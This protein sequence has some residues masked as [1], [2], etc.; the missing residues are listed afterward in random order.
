MPKSTL[1]EISDEKRSQMLA[2]QRRSLV[3]RPK[4][5][6]RLRTGPSHRP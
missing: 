1:V 4:A 2:A 3:A 6:T 5:A